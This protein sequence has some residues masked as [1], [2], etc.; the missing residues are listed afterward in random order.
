MCLFCFVCAVKFACFQVMRSYKARRDA[1]SV[2]ALPWSRVDEELNT[3]VQEAQVFICFVFYLSLHLLVFICFEV[4]QDLHQPE[5]EE[6]VEQDPHQP[7]QE[8]VCLF[9]FLCFA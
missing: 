3:P 2:A 4:E 6:Q 5:Q 7:E 8:L 1:E 9:M